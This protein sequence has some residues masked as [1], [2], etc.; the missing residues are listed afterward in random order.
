MTYSLAT[1]SMTPSALPTVF[2]VNTAH[3]KNETA[4]K[5][6]NI[7]NLQ[8]QSSIV[9]ISDKGAEAG[10]AVSSSFVAQAGDIVSLSKSFTSSVEQ[11]STHFQLFDSSGNVIADNQGTSD[12]QTAYTSWAAGTLSITAADTYTT[13]ATPAFGTVALG[14]NTVQQQGT[15]LQVNSQLTGGNAAEYYNFSLSTGNNIKLALDAGSASSST[16]VQLYDADGHIVADS[17]GNS[18]QKSNFQ[19]LT[20]GTGLTS[21]VGNYSVKVSYAKGADTNKDINYTLNL[22]SGSTYAVVYKN[23]VKANP[24]D[25]TAAGSVT[26]TSDAQLYSR[27]GYNAINA[28]AA[29][30]VNIGWITQDKSSLNVISQL[31]NADN[32]DYYSFTLQ[33]GD[34]LKFG[35]DSK[36]TPNAAHIRVQVLDSSGNQVIADSAG[37]PTQK[38]AY[39]SLTTTNGLQA[40]AGGYVAKISYA[41]DAPK[42]NTNYTFNIYSGTSYAAQYRTIASPQ[43][44]GNALLTGTVGVKS[45]SS[46]MAAYLTALAN[47]DTTDAMTSALSLKI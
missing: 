12:Q 2:S 45:A 46:G 19:A 4:A 44:Y 14:I 17:G 36:N 5:A 27:Q 41:P 13:V 40:K 15:S 30:A 35:F 11:V 24:T 16:R 37:T 22:Y 26:P 43:T 29:T 10:S 18:F 20:S 8:E 42:V 25:N 3:P 31:T 39:K 47:G 9:S 38:A 7:G 34:N 23:N 33:S 28:T 21:S 1:S 32:T 6:I